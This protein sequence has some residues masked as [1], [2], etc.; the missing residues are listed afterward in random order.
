MKKKG[1]LAAVL[2]AAVIAGVLLLS[3]RPDDALALEALWAA[4]EAPSKPLHVTYP[5]SGAVFPTTMH[6]PTFLWT[7][8]TLPATGWM[9]SVEIQGQEKPYLARADHLSWK[10]TKA[11]W[12][13]MREGAVKNPVRVTVLGVTKTET[14]ERVVSMGSVSFHASP[15][16]VGGTVFFRD[17]P[18][19]FIYA[20][21]NPDTIR[22]RLGD[23]ASEDPAPV[24]LENLPVCGNCHSFTADGKTLAM[25]V[26]Y[27]NDKGSYAIV[28]V[29]ART[30]L[31]PDKVITW[32]DFRR[33]DD[34]P[35][36]GLLS[37]ISP[38]GR[39][40]ISTVRDRSV[41]VQKD[42]LTY[43]QLFFPVRG[44]LAVY[45]R[46]QRRFF[47][48]PGAD[49]PEMVQ[50][51]P[52]WSPDG[53]TVYFARTK[54]TS[55]H[56]GKDIT[57]VLVPPELVR[58]FTS[59]RRPFAFDIYRLPFNDGKGGK[60]E[61]VPGASNNGQSNFF[62]R[63]SPDGRWLVFCRAK[64]YMLLQP[65]SKLWILPL[66]GGEAR[67]MACNTPNM[68]SWHSWSPSGRWLVF[69]SKQRGPYTRL[70]L[71]HV[72]EQGLS[73]PAVMLENFLPDA[74]AANIPEFVN[75]LPG[76]I[77]RI[78]D[79]FLN[80]FSFQRQGDLLAQENADFKASLR[81]YR[82]ALSLNP[83]NIDARN[84]FGATLF[85][86]GFSE[87]AEAQLRGVLE[88]DPGNLKGL[89]NLAI[90]FQTSRRMDKA[91]ENYELVL[92]VE[93]EHRMALQ[94]LGTICLHRGDFDRAGELLRRLL[95][96]YPKSPRAQLSLGLLAERQEDHT[97][98]RRRFL[99]AMEYV[100]ER[101]Q[102]GLDAAQMLMQK[103][104]M[105]DA[106]AGFLNLVLRDQP[107]M[108]PALSLLGQL[109]VRQGK[110]A[111][112]LDVFEHLAQV[113][114]EAPDW[115]QEKISELRYQIGR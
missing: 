78:T 29:A 84:N 114:P 31:G 98:A 50:S 91:L 51:N 86:L 79:E 64:N 8:D 87:E 55:I 58:D 38:D 19:P 28:E 92:S 96:R 22:W 72:D 53:K 33:G 112:A 108:G 66:E 11:I 24:V 70:F 26:D 109:L 71:A 61:P 100:P 3:G 27:A 54:A 42:D 63:I 39:Y 57:S 7:D 45:D 17:V 52:S 89:V 73:A 83:D 111:L 25:D 115:L 30:V 41:F 75:I 62:P 74:R 36:F 9:V 35:T 34:V 80:D 10:P 106:V 4:R 20:V 43:S 107:D 12:H 85:S 56:K 90:I 104:G 16:P 21:K 99:L 47:A 95:S 15:D 5:P 14:A 40:V 103:K 32:S 67:E 94:N 69:A 101:I 6:T 102:D 37:Q 76:A 93:P 18:L 23:V 82:K 49:D 60:P 1:I 81:Y 77:Q 13:A 110:P 44:I 48:L 105:A 68:N 46:T 59:G 65:D 113:D 2:V 88:R 97:E